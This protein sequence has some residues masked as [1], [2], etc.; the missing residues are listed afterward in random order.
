MAKKSGKNASSDIRERAAR[1]REL[2][3]KKERRVRFIIWGVLAVALT[4]VA[5]LILWLALFRAPA[6]KSDALGAYADGSPIVVGREVGKANSGTPVVEEYLSYSCSHCSHVAEPIQQPLIQKAQAGEITV[7][8]AP[9]STA[10]IPYTD[11]ATAAAVVVANK[12]PGKFLAVHHEL[13]KYFASVLE[14]RDGSIVEDAKASLDKVKDIAT[15]AGVSSET[16]S[17]ITNEI[18]HEYLQKAS[19]KWLKADIKGIEKGQYGTPM[20]IVDGKYISIRGTKET[21]SQDLQM[22]LDSL[23]K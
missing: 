11:A 5:G 15:K 4:V 22:I 13:E 19:E 3:A 23:K 9:V 10:Q 16:V 12:E 8:L 6:Q 18:G 20:F 14:T 17:L 2:E 21:A 7:Q 1:M